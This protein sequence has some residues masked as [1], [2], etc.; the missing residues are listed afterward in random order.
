MGMVFHFVA[1]EQLWVLHEWLGDPTGDLLLPEISLPPAEREIPATG[2]A[3]ADK[4]KD[5][6][7]DALGQLISE[8]ITRGLISQEKGNAILQTLSRCPQNE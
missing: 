4:R 6:H 7:C 1:P 8:L 3:T 2:F 5:V